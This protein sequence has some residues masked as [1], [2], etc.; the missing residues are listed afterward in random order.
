MIIITKILNEISKELKSKKIFIF[1]ST[2][3][4]QKKAEKGKTKD[5]MTIIKVENPL[6]ANGTRKPGKQ[7]K[8]SIRFSGV[9]P[10]PQSPYSN[11][12]YST[13]AIVTVPTHSVDTLTH[14]FVIPR[15]SALG[16]GKSIGHSHT[17]KDSA[18]FLTGSVPNV[19]RKESL[20][21]DVLQGDQ[22]I[23]RRPIRRHSEENRTREIPSFS[24]KPEPLDGS[25]PNIDETNFVEPNVSRRK[26]KDITTVP[27]WYTGVRE[28][29]ETHCYLRG[30]AG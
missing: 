25:M 16:A 13:E 22:P 4:S 20:P 3:H 26:P 14:P 23:S 8:P 11:S 19:K 10:T 15:T 24:P 5:S 27:F 17:T 18:K 21:I 2:E 6:W 9:Q 30:N 7:L 12:P 29:K 1:S 28:G